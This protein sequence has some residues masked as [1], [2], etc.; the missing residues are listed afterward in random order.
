MLVLVRSS[1]GVLTD[2]GGLQKEAFFHR[3][4]CVTLRT[5]T[6]WPETVSL[7]WNTLAGSDTE[8]IVAAGAQLDSLPKREG[9]P[10]GDGHAADAIARILVAGE[11][12]AGGL[13][14]AS[15]AV[16]DSLRPSDRDSR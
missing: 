2:S 7:G 4:P 16:S 13:G 3:V 15:P 8:S 10:Y 9:T 14:V 1:R 11:S 12:A 6:E 5:E